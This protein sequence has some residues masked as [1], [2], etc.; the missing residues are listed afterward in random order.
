[1]AENAELTSNH[2]HHHRPPHILIFP[3]LAQ[4]HIIPLV[5]MAILLS[6]RGLTVTLVTTPLNL[7]RI[8]PAIDLQ[9]AAGRDLRTVELPFP[10]AHYGL[11]ENC[12][13][14]ESA[15]SGGMVWKFLL[16]TRNLKEPFEK[17]MQET[18]PNCLI[19]DFLLTWTSEVAHKFNIPRICFSGTCSFSS[20]L[21]CSV[22]ERKPHEGVSS[23]YEPFLVPGLPHQIELSKAQMPEILDNWLSGDQGET[24][25]AFW[26]K[27][28]NAEK[29][30]D[31][32]IVND[33][34]ELEPSY[35][36]CYKKATG[37]PVWTVGPLFLCHGNRQQRGKKSSISEEECLEW[38]G[39]KKE[40]S[41]LYI[42]FGSISF[43][44]RLQMEEMKLGLENLGCFFIWVVKELDD[45]QFIDSLEEKTRDKGL[46]IRGWAPQ[47]VILSHPSIGAFLT[48][49][50]WNSTIE[51]ISFGVPMVTWPLFAEQHLN[52]KLVVQILG[53]GVKVGSHMISEALGE[54]VKSEAIVE[55]VQRVMWPGEEGKRLREKAWKAGDLARRA[56][57][58]QNGSSCRNVDDFI[59]FVTNKIVE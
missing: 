55:A 51:A 52:E 35:V 44:S 31:G 40:R 57:E 20:V 22:H 33:F 39:S 30:S 59:Q 18:L 29:D 25:K 3:F 17:I 50:G 43:I 10:S 12:E 19:S 9:K 53:I 42:S 7:A 45:L 24:T 32:I 54:V 11:P 4:G 23:D 2:A 36:E 6:Q 21:K 26:G 8:S 37:K 28:A 14:L 16:S 38:L 5:D 27:V 48:H 41:V 49:C 15:T 1:M 13:S 47:A 34:Y 58:D 56:V 46:I